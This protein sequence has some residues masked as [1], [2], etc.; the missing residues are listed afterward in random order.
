MILVSP[1]KGDMT[2]NEVVQDM[3]NYIDCSTTPVEI[4]V[5]TDSQNTSHTKFVVVLTMYRVG[6]GGRFF[7]HVADRPLITDLRTKI[8][9]E[10]QT[11]LSFAEQLANEMINEGVFHNIIIHVDIGTVGKTNQLI[12]EIKGWVVGQ[13]YEVHIKPES[14][15]ASAVANRLTK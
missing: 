1:T 5:G 6:K 2:L 14:Y 15:A 3:R 4:V 13:G 11:T 12:A 10:T 8:Y 7:Y 9:Q